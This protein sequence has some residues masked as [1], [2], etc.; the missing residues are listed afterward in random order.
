MN[1]DVI[2]GLRDPYLE[3]QKFH[4]FPLCAHLFY[5]FTVVCLNCN[6]P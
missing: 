2:I 4:V 3:K 1:L 6:T 5:K